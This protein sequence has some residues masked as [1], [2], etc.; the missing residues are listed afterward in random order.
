MDHEKAI[1]IAQKLFID[2]MLKHGSSFDDVKS[3]KKFPDSYNFDSFPLDKLQEFAMYGKMETEWSGWL[4]KRFEN[5]NIEETVFFVEGAIW[6]KWDAFG[7]RIR[8]AL[9]AA[10]HEYFSAFDIESQEI[11]NNIA[12]E[13][14]EMIMDK[15]EEELRLSNDKI[16]Y[17][18]IVLQISLNQL[19][20][21]ATDLGCL[22][23]SF[24]NILPIS[25]KFDSYQQRIDRLIENARS[26]IY[27]AD[28]NNISALN[29]IINE[30]NRLIPDYND[31]KS[32]DYDSI[33]YIRE[34]YVSYK[35]DHIS[36][37]VEEDPT[38]EN[39]SVDIDFN[40][41][42]H[43]QQIDSQMGYLRELTHMARKEKESYELNR[44][45]KSLFRLQIIM[46]IS[47][48]TS[49]AALFSISIDQIQ[50]NW[51]IFGI[52]MSASVILTLLTYFIISRK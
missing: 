18:L 27:S 31:I 40:P 13:V 9:R 32:F 48:F 1:Q 15:D 23:D 7:E 39:N 22:I 12:D 26:V 44:S 47:L 43:L 35:N 45:S 37:S 30:S 3:G 49:V 16:D 25:S 6:G 4:A 36:L 2:E 17:R 20:S 46:T 33:D 50:G 21:M 51:Q 11:T 52:I 42:H 5:I 14:A 41:E 29:L 34:L 10:I 28:Y 38:A 19:N 8:K 24:K